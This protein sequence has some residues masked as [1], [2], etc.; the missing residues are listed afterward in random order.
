METPQREPTT[1]LQVEIDIP[2]GWRRGSV[3]R[4]FINDPNAF[5]RGFQILATHTVPPNYVCELTR[6]EAGVFAVL[7]PNPPLGQPQ[8]S[9]I[10]QLHWWSINSDAHAAVT[11][12]PPLPKIDWH[13]QLVMSAQ[14]PDEQNQPPP[15]G[16]LV[17]IPPNLINPRIIGELAALWPIE[18]FGLISYSPHVVI[19]GPRIVGLLADWQQPGPAPNPNALPYQLAQSWGIMEGRDLRYD[20][21]EARRLLIGGLT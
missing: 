11:L 17:P 14:D 1:R 8:V 15:D 18:R 21:E 9:Q 19:V 5:V 13:L 2:Q 6:V 10:E 20:S 16:T 3:N 4:D 7:N 12:L